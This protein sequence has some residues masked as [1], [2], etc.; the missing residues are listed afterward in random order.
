MRLDDAPAV[1][2]AVIDNRGTAAPLDDQL[3]AMLAGL[4]GR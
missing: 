2:H 1:P 3:A 4:P